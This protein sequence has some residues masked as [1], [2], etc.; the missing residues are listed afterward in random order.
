MLLGDGHV[1]ITLR[2]FAA[3]AHQPRAL[4]HGR[5]YRQQAGIGGGHV[6]QPV[7][8]HIGIGQLPG[9]G[10]AHQPLQRI[11]RGDRVIADLVALGQSVALALGGDDVQQL[12][13]LEG[14]QGLERADQGGHVVAVDRAGVMEA[15]FLEQSGRHEHAL[16][17]LF[18]A[19][20]EARRRLALVA[21]QLLAAFAQRTEGAAAADAA[22]HLGHAAHVLGDRHL[23]VVE[24][25]QQVGL[26]VFHAAGVVERLEG[27][28]RGECAVADHRHHSAVAAGVRVGDRHAQPRRDGGGGM[29]HPE[30]VVFAFLALGERRHTVGLLDRVD[31]VAAPGQD[32]VR[33]GLVADVPHQPIVGR[34]VQVVQGDGEL[35]HAEACAEVTAA[36]AHRLDQVGTQFVGDRGELGF[37]ELAQV[38]GRLDAREARI[39]GGVDHPGHFP[40]L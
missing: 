17:V 34:V 36:A 18:P 22:Q 16:P 8:E 29:A 30:G 21:Q 26:R 3:E 15:H 35:D 27:H 25:H 20:H 12:W 24:D 14:L 10:L 9:S 37:V 11:E 39:A 31:L 33:I 19:P 4:A 13:A 1:E 5:G 2:V 7:A 32:L 23:V 6:A 28:A 38:G 40:P